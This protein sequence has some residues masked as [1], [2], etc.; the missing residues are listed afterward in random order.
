MN[1]IKYDNEES[2]KMVNDSSSKKLSFEQSLQ[3]LQLK[4]LSEPKLFSNPKYQQNKKT[5]F[6]ETLSSKTITIPSIFSAPKNISEFKTPVTDKTKSIILNKLNPV[7]PNKNF[8]KEPLSTIQEVATIEQE[9]GNH[10]PKKINRKFSDNNY[11]LY[12]NFTKKQNFKDGLNNLVKLEQRKSICGILNDKKM[13][14]LSSEKMSIDLNNKNENSLKTKTSLNSENTNKY[15]LDN[16]STENDFQKIKRQYFSP[17]IFSNHFPNVSFKYKY[18]NNYFNQSKNGKDKNYK[19]ISNISRNN[20]FRLNKKMES[21]NINNN[22]KLE[23]KIF[24]ENVQNND[25]TFITDKNNI[26]KKSTNVKDLED[27]NNEYIKKTENTSNPFFLSSYIHNI[28]IDVNNDESDLLD[29]SINRCYNSF[30]NSIDNKINDINNS[31]SSCYI[32][33]SKKNSFISI[34]P[35]NKLRNEIYSMNN[36]HNNVDYF[37]SILNTNNDSKISKMKYNNRYN[38]L[39][40]Y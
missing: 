4:L 10:P 17:F 33:N 12:D 35:S 13:K 18:L 37:G 32:N 24:A 31:R 23:K 26:S 30:I 22:L 5:S 40:K 6:P 28:K 34:S 8:F 3:N 21:K 36:Y 2:L 29:Q 9:N 15:N 14:H 1:R 20:D 38:W 25:K 39:N 7:D 19:N 16:T 27:E 11:T